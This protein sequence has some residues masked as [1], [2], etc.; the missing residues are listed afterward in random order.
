MKKT[1]HLILVIFIALIVVPIALAD[2]GGYGGGTGTPAP[3][4]VVP[5]PTPTP[6]CQ[7]SGNGICDPGEALQLH[8]KVRAVEPLQLFKSVSH[9]EIVRKPLVP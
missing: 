2:D 1:T 6:L 3:T 9:R 5:V 8:I 7:N 4:S